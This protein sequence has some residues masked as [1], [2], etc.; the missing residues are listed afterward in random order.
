MVPMRAAARSP[1]VTTIDLPPLDFRAVVKT[2]NEE[3]RTVDLIFSTGAAVDRVD[4]WTGQRYV[5]KLSLDPAHVRLERLNA[6]APLLDT[7][8]SYSVRNQLGAI[9]P[10]SARLELGDGPGAPGRQ[11]WRRTGRACRARAGTC[12][13]WEMNKVVVR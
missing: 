11:R 12:T 10:G 1:H 4:W 7:H 3:S 8:D 2:V 6:G 9:E 5:E 13:L